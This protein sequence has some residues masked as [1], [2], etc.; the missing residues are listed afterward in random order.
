MA[1]KDY[2]VPDSNI[3]IKKGTTVF[4]SVYAIHHDEEYFPDPEKFDPERFTEENKNTRPFE[5]FLAFGLGNRNCIGL[6]FGMLETKIGLANL[7]YQFR[8]FK[9]ERTEIPLKFNKNSF[10]LSPEGG[11]YLRIEKI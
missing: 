1:T 2:P 6:R 7:L 8:F 11:L 4:A 10:V 3:I 5:S 9:S